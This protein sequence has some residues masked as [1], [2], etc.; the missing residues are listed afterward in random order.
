[1][2]GALI[3]RD[4]EE[5]NKHLSRLINQEFC[6]SYETTTTPGFFFSLSFIHRGVECKKRGDYSL[7][8]FFLLLLLS[9]ETNKKISFPNTFYIIKEKEK[10]EK[11][12]LF[13]FL[14]HRLKIVMLLLIG[15]GWHVAASFAFLLA[16]LSPN[17]LTVQTVPSS[18]NVIVQR[19]VFYVCD[20]LS[21]NNTFQTTLCASIINLDPSINSPG[22]WY[23]S[24]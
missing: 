21:Q 17:W 24:K 20:S 8:D 7:S 13:L 22:R 6:N 3:E 15:F 9:F 18:G 5:L 23:Y 16:I 14:L 1:M 19:G 12:V 4:P 11:V 2:S 10:G